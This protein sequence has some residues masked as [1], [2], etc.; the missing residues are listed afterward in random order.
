MEFL[1]QHFS[2]RFKGA[3]VYDPDVPDTINL[4]TMLAGLEDRLMLAPE[5]LDLPVIQSILTCTGGELPG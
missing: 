1:W 4:A 5:Q 3:V 2:P